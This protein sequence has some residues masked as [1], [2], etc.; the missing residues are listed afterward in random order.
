MRW[1]PGK[2]GMRLKK[3]QF[4]GKQN[5]LAQKPQSDSGP[6]FDLSYPK[7]EENHVRIE[8]QTANPTFPLTKHLTDQLKG[9]STQ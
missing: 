2:P 1:K 8:A 9:F 5:A 7:Q 4:V 6:H 3:S